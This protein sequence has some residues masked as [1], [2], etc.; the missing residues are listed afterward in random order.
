M[1]ELEKATGRVEG[2]RQ[3]IIYECEK[4]I[5]HVQVT[6]RIATRNIW[7]QRQ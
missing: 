1:K 2:R 6:L 4:E 5:K 3:Y 7:M